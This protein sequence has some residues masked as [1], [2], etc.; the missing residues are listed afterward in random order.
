M[1]KEMK[2]AP[3]GIQIFLEINDTYVLKQMYRISALESNAHFRSFCQA[4]TSEPSTYTI[5]L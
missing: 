2:V 4:T 5:A 3:V 1:D